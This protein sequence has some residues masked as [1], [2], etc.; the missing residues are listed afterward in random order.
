MLEAKADGDAPA[1]TAGSFRYSKT[2]AGPS[3]PAAASMPQPSSLTNS[4]V[5]AKCF[6][7][8]MNRM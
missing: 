3:G 4:R 5:S 6:T 7:W 1:G 8:P 2:A